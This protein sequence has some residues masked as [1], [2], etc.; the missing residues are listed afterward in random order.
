MV[1][2]NFCNNLGNAYLQ[3]YLLVVEIP[4]IEAV[5]KVGNE[6]Q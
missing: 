5:V 4:I 1:V 6:V 2:E 3:C